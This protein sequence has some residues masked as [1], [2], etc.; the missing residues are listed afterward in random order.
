MRAPGHA[1]SF[2]GNAA[3][4]GS[5]GTEQRPYFGAANEQP[6]GR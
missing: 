3:A 4:L 2:F 5:S 1:D 6:V